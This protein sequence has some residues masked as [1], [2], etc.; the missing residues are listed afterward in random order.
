MDS[1]SQ[2][3]HQHP[4]SLIFLIFLSSYDN[5]NFKSTSRSVK[6]RLSASTDFWKTTLNAPKFVPD[7]IRLPLSQN[8]CWY[9]KIL[10]FRPTTANDF[11]CRQQKRI[12]SEYPP[13]CFLAGNLNLWCKPSLSFSPMVALLNTVFHYFA[14]TPCQLL[15]GRSWARSSIS[16]TLPACILVRFKFMYEDLRSLPQVIEEGHRFFIWDLKSEYHHVDICLEH[17]TSTAH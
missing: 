16:G 5:F 6:G 7:T 1:S 11:G 13:S 14:L 9:K 8:I 4:V 15:K 10:D 2:D 17:Q 12:F 3:V